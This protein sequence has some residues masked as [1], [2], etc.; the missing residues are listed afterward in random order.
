MEERMRNMEE[1][2]RYAADMIVM[3]NEDQRRMSET[4]RRMAGTVRQ[5]AESVQQLAES[6]QEMDAAARRRDELLQ[7]MLQAVAVIQADI[8]RIDETH[9]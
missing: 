8:V 7:Q 9:T 5:L 6:V 2:A 4:I 3:I 1:F